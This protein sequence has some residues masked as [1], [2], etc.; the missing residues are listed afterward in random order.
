MEGWER[1]SRV[2]ARCC[3]PAP[4]R[5]GPDCRCRPAQAQPCAEFA[6]E[7]GMSA[8]ATAATHSPHGAACWTLPPAVALDPAHRPAA[9][10]LQE[11]ECRPTLAYCQ[12]GSAFTPVRRSQTRHRLGAMGRAETLAWM[13]ALPPR[14]SARRPPGARRWGYGVET[15]T[16]AR[17]AAQA[18]YSRPLLT[19]ASG[20]TECAKKPCSRDDHQGLIAPLVS[21]ASGPCVLM[22]AAAT[23]T[24]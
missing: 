23:L 2:I 9:N 19:T 14:G 22:R 6:C 12:L 7:R 8:G 4:R 16:A 15:L 18:K 21:Q 20:G 1:P 11:K 10:S 13:P 24:V 3:L 17:T 5:T